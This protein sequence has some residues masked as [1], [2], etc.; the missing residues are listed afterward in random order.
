MHGSAS[1]RPRE[2]GELCRTAETLFHVLRTEFDVDAR[3]TLDLRR[4]DS[5]GE[6][7]SSDRSHIAVTSLMCAQLLHLRGNP[8]SKDEVE[9]VYVLVSYLD[10][11]LRRL[12]ESTSGSSRTEGKLREIHAHIVE[13]GLRLSGPL[14]ESGPPLPDDR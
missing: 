1:G 4:P 11:L 9:E 10:M 3:V 8:R 6:S 2:L 14:I 12:L 13:L 5:L 7:D